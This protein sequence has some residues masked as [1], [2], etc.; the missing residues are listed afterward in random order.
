MQL[1][2]AE[3]EPLV[4]VKLARTLE[5]VAEQVHNDEPPALFCSARVTSSVITLFQDSMFD[6]LR[7]KQQTTR[8]AT[9]ADPTPPVVPK[10]FI[11]VS[12]GGEK[13]AAEFASPALREL[14]EEVRAISH[15]DYPLLDAHYSPSSNMP[16]ADF[17]LWIAERL[18]ANDWPSILELLDFFTFKNEIAAIR[19]SLQNYDFGRFL[20]ADR[21]LLLRLKAAT[22]LG[23]RIG[24]MGHEENRLSLLEDIYQHC[25]ASY[26]FVVRPSEFAHLLAGANKLIRK[27]NREGIG[28][29]ENLLTDDRLSGFPEVSPA[30]EVLRRFPPTFAACITLSMRRGT[31]IPGTILLRLGG[32]YGLRQY[33]LSEEQN[34]HFAERC[35]LFEAAS[36]LQALSRSLTKDVLLEVATKHHIEVAKSWKKDRILNLL[37][38]HGEA[39]AALASRAPTG[40]VQYRPAISEPFNAWRARVIA[41]QPVARCLACA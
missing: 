26:P 36:D 10:I 37:L 11:T 40:F 41:V 22:I 7:R 39:R 14:W 1:H 12:V 21:E 38:A 20:D 34:R 6:W 31:P 8:E 5:A 19:S 17:T 28:F 27:R 18:A 35:G 13:R 15:P 32:E 23:Y 24:W 33:G 29:N 4:G 3:A 9:A 30:G 16:C 25:L 2:L